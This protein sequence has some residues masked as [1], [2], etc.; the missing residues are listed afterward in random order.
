ML[1]FLLLLLLS[2]LLLLVIIIH[3]IIIMEMHFPVIV[4]YDYTLQKK[5]NY[6]QILTVNKVARFHAKTFILYSIYMAF[7]CQLYGK[8][9]QQPYMVKYGIKS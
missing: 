2:L 3:I 4:L 9:Q 6:I 1:L 5:L 7:S 8:E